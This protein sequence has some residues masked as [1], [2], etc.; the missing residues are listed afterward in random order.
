MN[1][2]NISPKKNYGIL[3]KL[4]NNQKFSTIPPLI[5][6]D[7]T[8]TDPKL[9]SDILNKYVASKST[10]SYPNDTPPQLNKFNVLSDLSQINT[11]Q[12]SCPRL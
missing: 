6:N 10:V 8:I 11:S 9:K 12:L 2:P 7:R 5:D 1:N 3:T 4:M